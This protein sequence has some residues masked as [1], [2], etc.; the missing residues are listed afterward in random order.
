[1]LL[2]L[3]IEAIETTSRRNGKWQA[4]TGRHRQHSRVCLKE[5]SQRPFGVM[6]IEK[7]N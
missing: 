7:G 1:M 5:K 6:E 3:V 2:K 4:D